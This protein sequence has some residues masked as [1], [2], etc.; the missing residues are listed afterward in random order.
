MHSVGAARAWLLIALCEAN[1]RSK[2]ALGLGLPCLL[3]KQRGFDHS[4]LV[5][6]G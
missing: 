1:R 6:A 5:K 4:C 2:Q 3:S